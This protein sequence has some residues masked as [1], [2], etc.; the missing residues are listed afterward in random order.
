LQVELKKLNTQIELDFMA[1]IEKETKKLEN[2]INVFSKE[3]QD[4]RNR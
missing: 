4:F 2:K 3:T 1:S